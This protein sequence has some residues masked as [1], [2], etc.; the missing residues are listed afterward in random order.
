MFHKTTVRVSMVAALAVMLGGTATADNVILPTGLAPGSQYQIAFVTTDTTS[1]TSGSESY[2]NNFATAE[3]APLTAILPLGT[4]WSAIT[5]TF[6]GEEFHNAISNAATYSGVPI[7]NT[8]GQLV[9]TGAGLWSGHLSSPIVY[10]QNGSYDSTAVWDGSNYTG[11][12]SGIPA[13]LGDADPMSGVSATTFGYWLQSS[14]NGATNPLAVY[15]LSS[16]ITDP[17]PE[18]TTLSLLV[19]ALLGLGAFYLRRRRAALAVAARLMFTAVLLATASETRADTITYNI[20]DYPSLEQ[21]A[22]NGGQDS[23]L[24]S[25][26]RSG[27][28]AKPLRGGP[29]GSTE[30]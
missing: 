26:C 4:S 12:A 7:Y 9:A 27:E 8:H 5:S 17:V 30:R 29:A 3:A 10:D 13:A 25:T 20:L 6:D 11:I 2:Y 19:S 14:T 23:I 24:G 16:P 21:D 1:G 28:C 15:A 18:P 22:Y